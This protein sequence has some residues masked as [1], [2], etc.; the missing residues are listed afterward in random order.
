MVISD[1]VLQRFWARVTKKDGGCWEW[2][3]QTQHDIGYLYIGGKRFTPHKLA[4]YFKHGIYVRG[5]NRCGN[6]LCCNP[7]HYDLPK[8]VVLAMERKNVANSIKAQF[9][10]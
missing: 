2:T 3:G 6:K 5:K 4:L 9:L 10:T 8:R 7:D 1:R